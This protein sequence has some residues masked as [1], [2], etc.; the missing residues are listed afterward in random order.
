MKLIP[1]EIGFVTLVGNLIKEYPAD[2]GNCFGLRDE[3]GEEHR[4]VNFY[5]E[6]LREWMGRTG[7]K[8]IYVR[9]IPKSDH[10]W[11]ICDERIPKEWY[12]KQYCPACTPLRMLPL[13]QRK[14]EMNGTKYWKVKGDDGREYIISRHEI[15]ENSKRKLNGKWT[16]EMEP[17]IVYA[18]YIPKH[19]K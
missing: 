13:E 18:P 2:H 1:I 11:E 5:Y 14:R 3:N 17:G 10:I 8:D 4:V 15:K 16:V 6:N 12:A 7:Q 9:C 19:K